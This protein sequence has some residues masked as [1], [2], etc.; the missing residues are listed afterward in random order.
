MGSELQENNKKIV[1]RLFKEVLHAS[2]NPKLEVLDE[3]VHENYIQHNPLAG[4]GRAGLKNFVVNV[5]PALGGDA[6]FAASPLLQVNV[7]A[8]G[9]LVVRQEIRKNW[10]LIDVFRVENSMLMEHWEAWHFEPGFQRPAFM[11][12]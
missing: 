9:D 1:E 6:L 2:S 3:L 8:E 11:K 12:S 5:I 10:M 4:Q 7:I